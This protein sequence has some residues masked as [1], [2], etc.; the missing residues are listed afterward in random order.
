MLWLL[1]ASHGPPDCQARD[2]IRAEPLPLFILTTDEPLP[3]FG[4]VASLPP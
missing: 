2:T 1:P 3:L 4:L